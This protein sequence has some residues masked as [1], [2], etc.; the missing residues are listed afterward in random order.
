MREKREKTNTNLKKKERERKCHA[1]F[2]PDSG[3]SR[4]FRPRF[5]K[6]QF[7]EKYNFHFTFKLTGT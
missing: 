3:R 1:L 7:I 5:T 2:P 4:L 6:L